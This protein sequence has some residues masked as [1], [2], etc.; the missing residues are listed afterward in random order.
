MRT[1][2]IVTLATMA[3]AFIGFWSSFALFFSYPEPL[4]DWLIPLSGR[5]EARSL[6]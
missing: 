3:G 2:L 4:G 5:P 6:V 1:L